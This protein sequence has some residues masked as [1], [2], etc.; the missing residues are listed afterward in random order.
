VRFL[1]DHEA[2]VN[3]KSKNAETPLHTSIRM[4]ERDLGVINVVQIPII[5]LLLQRGADITLP[6]PF[7]GLTIPKCIEQIEASSDLK[8]ELEALF[9]QADVS[10]DELTQLLKH[11]SLDRDK[12]MISLLA[13][14]TTFNLESS[15]SSKKNRPK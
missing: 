5:R 1:L 12:D 4:I 14:F 3:V 6:H 11:H 9:N 2:D 7:Y 13:A 10:V 8:N 15:E